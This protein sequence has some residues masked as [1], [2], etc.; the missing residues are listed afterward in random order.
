MI[1]TPEDRTAK[2]LV[3]DR[4]SCV[5]HLGDASL[6]YQLAEQGHEVVVAGDDV[7]ASRHPDI[8][9]VRSAG[10]RLPF[11]GDAFDVVIVPELREAPTALAEYA[12]VLRRDG[13]LSTISRHHDDS[14]PWMRKLREITGARDS[15]PIPAD[16]FSASGLFREPETHEVGSW[17]KL[18]LPGLLRFAEATKHPSVG[19]SA[20][21]QV[22][23][24]FLS[25][26]GQTGFLRL[27]HETV[28]IRARVDKAAMSQD[29]PPPDTMLLDFR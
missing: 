8:Q 29:V 17:E 10:E 1:E 23:D 27:R 22:R 12:R 18:D 24:L 9:Y 3:G 2:W 11:V 16:T 4:L 25:Y 6:A 26:A 13:L 19:D 15:A 7:T 21:S 20:L 14:I 5:L 28:C